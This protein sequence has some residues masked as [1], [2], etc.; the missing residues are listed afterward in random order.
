MFDQKNEKHKLHH[1]MFTWVYNLTCLVWH[2]DTLRIVYIANKAYIWP[3]FT[4][5]ASITWT[6]SNISFILIVA[7][8]AR[9]ILLSHFV[10]FDYNV[11]CWE[12]IYLLRRIFS[13]SVNQEWQINFPPNDTMS[14]IHIFLWLN[15]IRRIII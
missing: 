9:K 13:S 12:M 6:I 2:F 1:K 11:F 8:R 5:I 15:D 14:R 3:C 4:I 7:V 10:W